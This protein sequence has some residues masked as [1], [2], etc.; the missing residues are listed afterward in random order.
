[1]DGT[2]QLF[3]DFREALGP[4]VRTIVVSYP[5]EQALD[6]TELEAF[7]RSRL[8]SD[9]SF[10]ILGESFSGPIAVSIAASGASGLRGLILCCSFV[11]NPRPAL[12]LLRPVIGAVPLGLVPVGLHSR[13][14]LGRFA[15]PP[16]RCALA[17]ALAAVSPKA[18][19]TRIRGVLGVD[20]KSLLPRVRV[21]VLVLRATEDR[22]V[23]RAAARLV[24]QLLPA[25]RVVECEAPHLLLQTVPAEA[26]G[27]VRAFM[28]EVATAPTSSN[29][30]TAGVGDH[31]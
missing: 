11:K 3:T 26:A 28:R 21:P 2:G 14:L 24:S 5:P 17:R 29:G 22:V 6:Y 13:M 8:P 10:V 15:T 1:M 12:G 23:P 20:V 4:E 30:E 7:A 19:R 16:L 31:S 27:H 25:A 9:R 18:L